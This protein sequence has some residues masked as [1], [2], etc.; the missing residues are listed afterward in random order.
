LSKRLAEQ[1]ATEAVSSHQTPSTP[2][3]MKPPYSKPSAS[4]RGKK[5]PGR[6][7]GH[8]GSRRKAPKQI[9]WTA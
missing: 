7:P 4:N 1:K 5:K 2:S 3:G 8:P 6:K 9:D